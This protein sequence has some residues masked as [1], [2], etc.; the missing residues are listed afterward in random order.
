MRESIITLLEQLFGNAYA[1]IVFIGSAI[2]LTE[3]RATI[4]LGIYWGLPPLQVFTLALLG[5]YIPVPF[6]L[7]F[8]RRILAWMHT[9]SWL[10]WFTG[11][12]DRK[13]RKAV[14]RFE[15]SSE[16]AL[17]I[18]VAIPLPG[19]GL[20]TGSAVASVLGLDL[21]KSFLCVFLGGVLSAVSLTVV[22][23]LLRAGFSLF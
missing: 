12:V 2:P 5:S 15:K 14:T 6:L 3:Q 4:P 20:W 9:V 1:L 19:T 18:F 21:K 8:F 11:F 23:S 17:I 7:L 16:L 13:I 10:D 22:F